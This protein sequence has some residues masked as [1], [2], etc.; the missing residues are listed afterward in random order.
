MKK[1]L[2]FCLLTTIITS[3][4]NLNKVTGATDNPHETKIFVQLSGTYAAYEV[5]DVIIGGGGATTIGQGNQPQAY[6][7]VD[8]GTY[9]ITATAHNVKGIWSHTTTLVQGDQKTINLPCNDATVIVQP[10]PLWIGTHNNFDV[11]IIDGIGG[12]ETFSVGAG[13][14]NSTTVHPGKDVQIYVTDAVSGTLVGSAIV[15]L[16]YD[17][18][19]TLNVPY[20]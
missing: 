3:G 6:A 12:T 11:K 5:A 10:D 14:T 9:T 19:F 16:F 17:A 1:I 7:A 8:P 2:A 4:C 18:K 15:N 13:A 20:H